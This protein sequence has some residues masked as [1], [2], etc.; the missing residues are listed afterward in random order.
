MDTRSDLRTRGAVAYVTCENEPLSGRVG[1]ARSWRL[2]TG[3]RYLVR[4]PVESLEDRFVL[5]AEA[6]TSI[7]AERIV[8]LRD[9]DGFISRPVH[10]EHEDDEVAVI[11]NDGSLFPGDPVVMRGAFAL[12]LALHAGSAAADPHAGHDH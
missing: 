3:L 8:F 11:A 9:G 5:P 12:G 7:G 10:V 4:V 1:A 6:V 2:R